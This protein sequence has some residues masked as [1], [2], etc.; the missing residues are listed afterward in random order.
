MESLIQ[1][2]DFSGLSITFLLIQLKNYCKCVSA[3]PSRKI[4]KTVLWY[5]IKRIL[6]NILYILIF[7]K[8]QTQRF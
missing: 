5:N 7:S 3:N 6:S 4:V 1:N 8:L 2:K